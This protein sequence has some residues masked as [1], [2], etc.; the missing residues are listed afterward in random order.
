MKC[1]NCGAHYR[2]AVPAC[3]YCGTVNET[4]GR[5]RKKREEAYREYDAEH[6]RLKKK[7]VLWAWNHLITRILIVEVIVFVLGFGVIWFT[8][9]LEARNP[10][11][12]YEA[13]KTKIDA[14]MDTLYE[15]G[16]YDELYYR[17]SHYGLLTYRTEEDFFAYS[18]AAYLYDFMDRFRQAKW[19]LMELEEGSGY[20][21]LHIGETV[22]AGMQLLDYGAGGGR[23]ETLLPEHRQMAED[24]IA[25][26]H[27][28][29]A[30]LGLTEEDVEGMLERSGNVYRCPDA[31]SERIAKEKGW[32]SEDAP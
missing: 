22:N 7:G 28:F 24:A 3:P 21:E 31:L 12:E 25:D 27:R 13:E 6:A 14:E 2:V 10:E 30:Y 4:A 11:K 5:W 17:L 20:Y 19:E 1:V 8:D 9:R 32:L 15:E 18:Q 23:Q 29:F 26:V 16:R